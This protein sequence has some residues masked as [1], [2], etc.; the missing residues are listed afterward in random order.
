MGSNG[1]GLGV[2]LNSVR[3]RWIA[4][5]SCSTFFLFSLLIKSRMFC[6]EK[7][8]SAD[9]A[10]EGSVSAVDEPFS[11]VSEPLS[12]GDPLTTVVTEIASFVG[13]VMTNDVFGV[14]VSCLT[15]DVTTSCFVVA[16]VSEFFVVSS[17]SS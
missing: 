16:T 4:S 8:P 1:V 14:D 10:V 15:V 17:S 11:N 5:S 7:S 12:V 6:I 13:V 3:G 9:V 2:D